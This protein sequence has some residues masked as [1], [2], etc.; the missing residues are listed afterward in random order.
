MI[1]AYI[2]HWALKNLACPFHA[3]RFDI[4]VA[5]ENYYVRVAWGGIEPSE[6]EVQVRVN[7]NFHN[8]RPVSI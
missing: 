6:L 2:D 1:T 7:L 8:G 3:P 5:G 4:N